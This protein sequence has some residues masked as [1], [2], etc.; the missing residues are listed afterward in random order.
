[1][2]FQPAACGQRRSLVPRSLRATAYRYKDRMNG[3]PKE[4]DWKQ[5]RDMVE[6]LRER[7]LKETNQR[8]NEIL[9]DGDRTA[10]DQFW[11]TFEEMK[12]E[13][14]ILQDCLDQHSRSQMYL[15]MLLMLRYGML[16]EADLKGFS[17][18]LQE[19]LTTHLNRKL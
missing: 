9:T 6:F 12:K 4:S 3:K 16:K 14:K 19:Q 17:E 5:F 10:T 18:E 7:Y 13:K 11:D 8:L 1:M 2:K 15:S